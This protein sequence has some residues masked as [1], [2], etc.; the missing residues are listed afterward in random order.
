MPERMLLSLAKG[1]LVIQLVSG[2]FEKIKLFIS[3][4]SHLKLVSQIATEDSLRKKLVA[5][6]MI[7]QFCSHLRFL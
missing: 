6:Q 2:V 7:L 1:G 5:S 4:L 3:Y